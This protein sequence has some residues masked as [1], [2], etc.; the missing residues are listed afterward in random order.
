MATTRT[1]LALL[2]LGTILAGL[3]AMQRDRE[4]AAAWLL[5]LGFAF[6]TGWGILTTMLAA[7]GAADVP[8]DGAIALTSM[9]ALLTVYYFVSVTYRDPAA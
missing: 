7:D 1:I 9:A 3:Y 8:R 4:E 2:S 6:A 5:T